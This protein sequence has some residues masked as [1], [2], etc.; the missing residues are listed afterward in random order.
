MRSRSVRFFVLSIY[1]STSAFCPGVVSFSTSSLSGAST[2]KVTPNIV[3]AR[4]VKIVK[5][6]STPPVGELWFAFVVMF[7]FIFVSTSSILPKT[8][9]FVNLST[10]KPVSFRNLVLNRSASICSGSLWYSPSTSITSL[11]LNEMKSAIK[12]P[13]TCCLLNLSPSCLFLR[14]SHKA[15]SA[16]VG[17]CLFSLACSF[18]IS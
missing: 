6:P 4:V 7:F 12:S 18:R 5:A 16:S 9:S 1:A 2:M 10:V 11:L 15:F 3:S 13:I 8:S 17:F 14:A